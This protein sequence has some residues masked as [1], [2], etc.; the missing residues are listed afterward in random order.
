MAPNGK[1]FALS[2]S[3]LLAGV[4]LLS[5]CGDSS[6]PQ[7]RGVSATQEAA[8]ESASPGPG[9]LQASRD[10]P[11]DLPATVPKL[12]AGKILDVTRSEVSDGVIWG[13]MATEVERQVALDYQN[14]L[15]DAG[16]QTYGAPEGDEEAVIYGANLENLRVDVAW[17]LEN[18][19]FSLTVHARK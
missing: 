18:K 10:W 4:P 1:V 6:P 8:P 7:D 3:L 12:S 5:S 11:D 9:D 16:W 2:A 17:V 19:A 14:A 15:K 13:I